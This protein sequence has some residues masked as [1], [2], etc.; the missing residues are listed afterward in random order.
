MN[1]NIKLAIDSSQKIVSCAISIDNEI[2]VE[3]TI[4]K[5]LENYIVLIDKTLK[6]VDLTINDVDEL[7]VCTGPGSQMGIRNGIVTGNALAL[8]LNKKIYGVL[9][10]DAAATISNEK[11]EFEICVPAGRTNWYVRN[12][13]YDNNKLIPKDNLKLIEEE[14]EKYTYAFENITCA[15]AILQVA[16]NQRHMLIENK[17]NEV[18]QYE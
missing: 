15:R 3:E 8:A 7:Y 12:Y 5:S 17:N 13:K 16:I 2:K 18:R 10:I 14:T 11:D 4:E 1:K 9:S 6:K